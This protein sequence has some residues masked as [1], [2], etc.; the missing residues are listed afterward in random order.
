MVII[1]LNNI[2]EDL[3]PEKLWEAGVL[4]EACGVG[5][6]QVDLQCCISFWCT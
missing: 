5:S 4:D 1:H 2:I 3:L 6:H